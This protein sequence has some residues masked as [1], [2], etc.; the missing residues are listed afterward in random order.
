MSGM[1]EGELDAEFSVRNASATLELRARSASPLVIGPE[2]ASPAQ[3]AHAHPPTPQMS[4][5]GNS[6][7]AR[8]VREQ[9]ARVIP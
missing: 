2:I 3:Q 8:A 6:I 1:L 5:R 9:A 7:E 4:R